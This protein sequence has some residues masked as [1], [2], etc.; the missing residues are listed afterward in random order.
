[1]FAILIS[2]LSSR[3][4]CQL[5]QSLVVSEGL[6]GYEGQ[7]ALVPGKSMV[8]GQTQH[9]IRVWFNP[10]RSRQSGR[11]TYQLALT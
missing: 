4:H 5:R 7:D 11:C 10:A 1:M 2:A 8:E 3:L 9:S 6:C